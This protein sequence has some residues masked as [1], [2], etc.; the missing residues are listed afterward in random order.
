VFDG[1]DADR[2]V[3]KAGGQRD[4][5]DMTDSCGHFPAADVGAAEADA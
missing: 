3:R 2:V 5:A 1:V 4:P